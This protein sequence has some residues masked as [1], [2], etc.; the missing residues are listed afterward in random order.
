MNTSL[1]TPTK[2]FDLLVQSAILRGEKATKGLDA[3]LAPNENQMHRLTAYMADGRQVVVAQRHGRGG[4]DFNK[5]LG[6]KVFAVAADAL[7]PVFEKENNKPTKVQKQEDGKPLFSSSGFYLLSSKDYPALRIAEGY[8]R[9]FSDGAKVMFLTAEQLAAKESLS[10]TSDMDWEMAL[11]FLGAA[12]GD[13]RNMVTPFDADINRKRRRGIET[14]KGVAEDDQETYT[15]VEFTELAASKKDGNPFVL[16]T[17]RIDGGAVQTGTLMREFEATDDNDRPVTKYDDAD[18]A[19][20]RFAESAEGRQILAAC[21]AG[22]TVDFAFVQGHVMRTSVSF[23]RKVENVRAAGNDKPVYGDA[24]YIWGAL[25]GWVKGLVSVMQSMHPNF[26]A[27]DYDAHHYV[28]ACRQA[29]V[30]M[31]KKQDGSGWLPPQAVAYDLAAML[32]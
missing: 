26:P 28:A 1:P 27:K 25:T 11:A 18:A 29:E 21:E 7:S 13:D 19:V 5:L 16:Y 24:V 8:T 4:M 30:G 6:G 22:Q 14:A 15:G 31:T 23:R 17:W 9:L 32:A 20:A 12:L 3:Q 2:K 10:M